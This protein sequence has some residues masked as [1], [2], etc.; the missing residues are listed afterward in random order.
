MSAAPTIHKP[1]HGLGKSMQDK[2]TKPEGQKTKENKKVKIE[3]VP[4]NRR[5]E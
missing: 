5:K 1:D 3:K 4:E 2:K